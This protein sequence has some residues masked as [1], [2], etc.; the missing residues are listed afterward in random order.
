MVRARTIKDAAE[1]FRQEDPQTYLTETA[2]R[3]LVVTGRVP[4]AKVGKKYLV[5]L[6]ALEEYLNGP[7]QETEVKR[8]PRSSNWQIR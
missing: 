5:T 6:E 1:W 4:S 2:I 3:R 8:L 7:K